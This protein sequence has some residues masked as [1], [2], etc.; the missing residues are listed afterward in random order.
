MFSFRAG[1]LVEITINRRTQPV[2]LSIFS[3]FVY[4]K[5]SYLKIS[6]NENLHN[7]WEAVLGHAQ[8]GAVIDPLKLNFVHER[9]D[10][11]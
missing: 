11:L 5:S 3:W 6:T 1:K 7:L 2:S 8:F 4:S 9:L 10:Q